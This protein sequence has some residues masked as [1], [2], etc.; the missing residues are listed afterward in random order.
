MIYLDNAA[1]TFPK[2]ASMVRAMDACILGYCGNPG[3]SGHDMSM[4]T[5]EEVYRTRKEIGELF[6]IRDCSRIIFTYNATDGLNMAIKGVLKEGDHVITTA[7][8]HNSVLRP[9]KAMESKGVR[10]S[11]IHCS[12]DGFVRLESVEREINENTRLIVCTHASN[13]TGSVQP[14]GEIGSLARRKGILFLVDASQSAG[15]IPIDV[16][17]MGIDMMALPGHKGLLGPLGTGVLYVRPGLQPACLKE[18]GTGTNSRDLRQP[19]DFPEGYESGT[20]NAPGIIGL[21]QSARF[22]KRVGIERI[23]RH[24]EALIARLETHIDNIND[25]AVCKDK[26]VTYGPRIFRG[27]ERDAL[28]VH[29]EKTAILCM[30][31]KGMDCEEVSQ[32]LNE[33]RI[34]VRSGFHCAGIAHKTIGTIETGGV[35]FSAGPFNTM[36]EMDYTGEALFRIAG[37]RH[38]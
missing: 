1:T 2:P 13:V 10:T 30:N 34:A 8:E 29:G 25:M 36:R 15:S 31:I 6:C 18:G 24:E 3:R 33:C 5:G 14:I 23:R 11:I 9:L 19:L 20:V 35:R 28:S 27:Q 16:E 21:G 17:K 37:G 38:R 32:R 12:R 7:M 26:I 22:I 4:K